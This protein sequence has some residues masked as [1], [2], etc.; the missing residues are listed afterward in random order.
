MHVHNVYIYMYIHVYAYKFARKNRNCRKRS[1]MPWCAGQV[2]WLLGKTAT[3]GWTLNDVSLKF[4]R[5]KGEWETGKE[6]QA[7]FVSFFL[8]LRV[9]CFSV[10]RSSSEHFVCQI[11]AG[12]GG[13]ARLVRDVC[14]CAWD[15]AWF[16]FV[17]LCGFFCWGVWGCGCLFGVHEWVTSHI[18]MS[19]VTHTNESLWVTPHIWMSWVCM[20]V[21]VCAC[22]CVCVCVYVCVC[23][24]ETW[25]FRKLFMWVSACVHVCARVCVR[26]CA[27]VCVCVCMC[28][29]VCVC[30]AMDRTWEFGVL[31]RLVD[32]LH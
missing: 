26:V 20:R 6:I 4:S 21:R 23:A 9:C 18:R 32:L 30:V 28:V 10:T 8:N 25:D 2:I 24:T 22:Q 17:F 1:L 19:H 7:H 11:L 27:C 29:C 13:D 5:Q 15:C 12:K 3:Q 31:Q 16:D 14:L